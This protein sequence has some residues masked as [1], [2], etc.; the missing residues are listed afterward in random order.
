M[1]V[2]GRDNVHY[3]QEH[4]TT[5]IKQCAHTPIQNVN[6]KQIDNTRGA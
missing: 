2:G 1:H 4:A 3:Q 6:P 5:K